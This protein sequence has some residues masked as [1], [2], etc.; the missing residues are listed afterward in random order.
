MECL[1]LP[2]NSRLSSPAKRIAAMYVNIA[3]Y[4]FVTLDNLEELR[5]QYQALCNELGLKGTVLP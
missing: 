5:P 1:L 3:A 4:K 2:Y